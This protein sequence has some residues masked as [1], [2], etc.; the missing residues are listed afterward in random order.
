MRLNKKSRY[1]RRLDNEKI[2]KPIGMPCNTLK[3]TFID[4]DEFEAMRLCDYDGLSQVEAS[5]QMKVSRATVQRLLNS[6]R[7]KLIDAFLEYK[8]I[9]IKNETKN[10]K[11][12]GENNMN[13]NLKS[14]LK[15]AF[16]TTDK[17]NVDEHFGHCAYFAIYNV[18]DGKVVSNE[19][20]EAPPHEPGVFP[21]F[22]GKLN[23][24]VII[25]GG[26]G[27]RAVRLFK[28]QQIEVILGAKG[29]IS[30]NLNEYLEGF[31]ES[32]GDPCDKTHEE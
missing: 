31:L 20:V 11:L 10:I 22:L 15:I 25:T 1:C 8:I 27:Q 3:E 17:V 9:H 7:Y 6:G 26:M 13:T 18:K 28:E 2:Y 19:Y 21:K 24:S 32:K 12:K 23:V 5:E 14:E 30:D 4:L 29:P 16:P